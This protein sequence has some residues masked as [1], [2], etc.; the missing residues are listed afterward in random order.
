MRPD[1][2]EDNAQQKK[3]ESCFSS[4]GLVKEIPQVN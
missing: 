1:S 3:K 4:E 2:R